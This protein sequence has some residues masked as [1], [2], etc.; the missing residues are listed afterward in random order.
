MNSELVARL[1]DLNIEWYTNAKGF[2]IFSRGDCAAFAHNQP[3]GPSLG[4]SG[5]MTESG[6]AYLIWR[7]E[8]AYLVA[9]GGAEQPATDDQ[10]DAIR[11]FSSDLKQALTS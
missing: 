1:K 8:R 9:H 7:E 4:S 6:F 5:L 10:V 2:T 11:R 3:A